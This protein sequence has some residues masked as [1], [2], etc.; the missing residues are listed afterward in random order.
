V[1]G[2][3]L[4]PLAAL[5]FV[6]HRKRRQRLP[7]TSNAELAVVRNLVADKQGVG[8]LRQLVERTRPRMQMD[9]AALVHQ[10]QPIVKLA[11]RQRG[12]IETQTP[13]QLG[14][15]TIPQSARIVPGRQ[16][17]PNGADLIVLLQ[18]EGKPLVGDVANL[19]SCLAP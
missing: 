2:E 7:L 3:W 11:N 19:K 12:E 4:S 8:R 5:Q 6:Q 13:K 10:A 18:E 14:Q 1:S 17:C 9:L 16:D 15:G